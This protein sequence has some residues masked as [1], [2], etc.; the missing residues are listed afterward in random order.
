MGNHQKAVALRPANDNVTVLVLGVVRVGYGSAECIAKGR[1]GFAECAR[2]SR[3]L[4]DRRLLLVA[5]AGFYAPTTLCLN[6]LR[7][8]SDQ[9]SIDPSGKKARYVILR[10]DEVYRDISGIRT[11]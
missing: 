7:H 9:K 10:C 5:S 8:A 1:C 6:S 11:P 2:S 3:L 4:G